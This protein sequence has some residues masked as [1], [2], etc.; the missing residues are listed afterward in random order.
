MKDIEKIRNIVVSDGIELSGPHPAPSSD[1]NTAEKFRTIC[2][3][4]KCGNFNK[5][6]TC[7]P[8]VGIPKDCVTKLGEFEKAMI[9]TKTFPIDLSDE[10]ML[11][12]I[13]V[14]HQA[15]CRGV[16]KL[17]IKEGF[18]VLALTD[19]R[20]HYCDECSYPEPCVAPEEQM[21]SVSG[22]GIDMAEYITG[23]GIKF[24]FEKTT[25][26][27]YGIIMYK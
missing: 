7:P 3:T 21:P 26:T 15:I 17:F 19:G 5:S 13:I 9:I 12:G 20:C 10:A 27:L 8:A 16:K 2:K 24:T 6:W 23:C 18:E 25:A 11:N 22:Y 14:E 1:V 4:D